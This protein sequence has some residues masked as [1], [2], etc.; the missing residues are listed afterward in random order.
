LVE[1]DNRADNSKVRAFLSH[2]SLD[3]PF[4]NVVA[5][6]LGRRRVAFD[7]W[8]FEIGSDFLQEIRKGLRGSDS[9][10]LFASRNSLQSVWVKIEIQDAEE[11]LQSEALRQA[12]VLIIDA[13]V[14]PRDLPKWMQRGRIETVL[15]HNEAARIIEHKLNRLRGIE[16]QPLFIG[17]E[18]LLKSFSEELI[19]SAGETPPQ[20]VIAGGLPGVGRR[21]FLRSALSSFLSMRIGPEFYLQPTDEIDTLHLALIG[22]LGTLDGKHEVAEAIKQFQESSPKEKA[23][24][25]AQ[26]LAST[27]LGNV[28]PLIVDD[29]MLLD[30]QAKYTVEALELFEAFHAYPESMLAIAH[31]RR[32][33]VDDD[34]LKTLRAIYTRIPP[35]DLNSTKLLLIQNLR[36]Y[37]VTADSNQI[38]ELAPYLDGY[39]PAINLAVGVAR[40]YGMPLL[41]ADKSGLVDFQIRTFASVLEKLELTELEWAILRVLATEAV[42]PLEGIAAVAEKPDAELTVALRRLIDLNLVLPAGT[43]FGIS[44]PIKFAAQSL[45][46]RLSSNEFAK[47]AKQLKE[48][49]WDNSDK[50]PTVEIIQATVHALIRSESN[51]LLDFRGFVLPSMLFRSAKEFYDRGGEEAWGRAKKLLSELL[52]VNADHKQG[53][54][55]LFKINVRLREWAEAERLLDA[56]RAKR[57]PEQHYLTGF[58]YWKKRA[59]AKAVSAFQTALAVGQTSVG[60][61]HGLATC[62]FRL[63]NIREAEKVIQKGLE[64]R[65]PHGLLLDLAA[66]VAIAQKNY[67]DAEKYIDQLHRVRSDTDFY[68]HRKATLL[69]AQKRFAAALPHAREA[70]KGTRRR[71]EMEATY[72]DIMIELE[73]FPNATKKLEELDKL[74]HFAG[75]KRDVV[76]G[77][78]CKLL[79]RQRKWRTAEEIWNLLEDKSSPVHV[80]LRMNIL[81]QQMEDLTTTPGERAVAKA[82][83]EKIR[84]EVNPDQSFWSVDS[85]VEDDGLDPSETETT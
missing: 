7:A 39:P 84:A 77:L 78:K 52:A 70:T 67:S 22:E 33:N 3:K 82:E 83:L 54:I 13:T 50:I 17:R 66:Q 65:R 18:E 74:G 85:D 56:I 59:F 68:H 21:S 55:L 15:S 73:D 71:F 62:L 32:P 64:G 53:L 24:R 48:S 34:Q 8:S 41:L 45:A 44:L 47:I 38:S 5:R 10:V 75:D 19:P 4:V 69:N 6:R 43:N 37:G 79:L 58:L 30:P 76:L 25:V 27:T 36:R 72:I 51:E 9:F 20:I 57:L 61:Y 80:A 2:S 1:I 23:K 63:D 31:T 60:V 11:L 29:G 35:L 12:T 28:V 14:Q 42:L 81:E 49:F 40:R 26:M 16:G 46:G